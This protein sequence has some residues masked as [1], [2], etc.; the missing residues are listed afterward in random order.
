MSINIEFNNYGESLD[1]TPGFLF[2][3]KLW[4][5]DLKDLKDLEEIEEESTFVSPLLDSNLESKRR[6]LKISSGV[7]LTKESNESKKGKNLSQTN[8][9]NQTNQ[10]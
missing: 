10:L 3:K 8:Q 5:E 1:S 4:L 6:A 9:T 7:T 2:L